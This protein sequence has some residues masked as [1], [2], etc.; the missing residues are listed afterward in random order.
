[1]WWWSF[2][3]NIHIENYMNKA[4]TEKPLFYGSTRYFYLKQAGKNISK[5]QFYEMNHG[6]WCKMEEIMLKSS[7]F[8]HNHHRSGVKMLANL[9][10]RGIPKV[11]NNY[12]LI[13][14]ANNIFRL[15]RVLR[16]D[17]LSDQYSESRHLF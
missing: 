3:K 8:R 9:T 13:M 14:D 15:C 5:V 6:K 7:E 1:V 16:F 2:L 11:T 17:P 12:L 4:F 10:R